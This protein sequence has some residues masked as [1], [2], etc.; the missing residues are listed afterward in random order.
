MIVWVLILGYLAI[1]AGIAL[2]ADKRAAQG[3]SM[4]NNPYIYALSW[5][6]YCTA[7]TF[8]GSVERAT[9]TGLGFLA[10]YLGPSIGAPFSWIILRKMIR[11]CRLYNITNIA[12]FIAFRYGKNVGLG[13]IVTL[14]TVIGLLPYI[15]IQLKAI[16]KSAAILIG[17]NVGGDMAFYLT[18]LLSF[19]IIWFG[20]AR[21]RLT[22][23]NEGFVMAIAM[24]SVVKLIA[25]SCVGIFVT[26]YLFDGFQD[27][28][29]RLAQ[30]PTYYSLLGLPSQ[31]YTEWACI[32]LI[33]WCAVLFL[34]RQFQMAVVENVEER[35]LDTAVWLFPLYLFAINIFVIPIA[36]GGKLLLAT[37]STS[38][39]TYVLAL[40]LMANQSWLAW[41]AFFGGF[42]AATSMV[43]VSTLAISLMLSNNIVMPI[44]A[45]FLTRTSETDSSNLVGTTRQVRRISIIF[46]LLL[47]YLYDKHIAESYSLVSIGLISFA[48][49][50]QFA[51]AII[52]GLFWKRANKQ[53]AIWGILIGFGIWAYTLV[54][55]TF[56]EN[57]AVHTILQEGLFGQTWLRPTALFG[58]QQIGNLSQAVFWSLSANIFTYVFV[59]LYTPLTPIEQQQAEVLVDIYRYSD[60]DSPLLQQRNAPILDING[61]LQNFLGKER[62]DILKEAFYKKYNKVWEDQQ[63]ADQ[64]MVDFAEKSLTEIIGSTAAHILVSSVAQTQ[65][66]TVGEMVGIVKESQEHIALNYALKKATAQLQEAYILLQESDIQKDEFLYTITHELRTPLT[67]IRAMSEILYDNTDLHPKDQQEFLEIIIRETERMGRLIT[68]VLDLERLER[69]NE[70]LQRSTV[71]IQDII[72]EV[73]Y[74]MM[75]LIVQKNITYTEYL[76]PNT[77]PISLDKDKISQVLINLFSNAI[78]FC[79]EQ[80]GK[81]LLATA[82]ENN[83]LLVSLTDNGKGIHKD[84]HTLIF[85][86]FYQAKAHRTQNKPSGS[87]L[88]LAICKKIITLHKGTIYVESDPEKGATFTFIL[89]LF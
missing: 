17:N 77:P 39:D 54:L 1:L 7:W 84:F 68:Q 26:Y 74:S 82:I 20:T 87:G 58:I 2:W 80:G 53:G 45:K 6:V 24:E 21:E 11:I 25:F 5:A 51:P 50:T 67:S 36:L 4:V 89:P 60:R 22:Q 88:G 73:K 30:H 49:I 9:D 32:L 29:N 75:P 10:V 8:Y 34:P 28:F 33:S 46:V 72:N 76:Q 59:S 43:V 40:P 27:I 38:P 64:E 18:L 85:D 14:L 13:Q 83:Q 65:N 55:P 78:K 63:T 41:I 66:V 44:I 31:N 86:K 57:I 23:G 16:D 79:P 42:S 70:P 19:F 61:L 47:A 3:R 15:A 35:H 56:Q 48:A 71:S 81:I 12:D 62:T 69:K 52:G 37:T